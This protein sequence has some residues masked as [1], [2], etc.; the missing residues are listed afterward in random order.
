[1]RAFTIAIAFSLAIFTYLGNSPADPAPE[2]EN[3]T[4]GVS[5][6]N[7]GYISA[8]VMYKDTMLIVVTKAGVA[9]IVFDEPVDKGRNYRFR[10]LPAD[11]TKEVTGQGAVWETYLDGKYEGANATIKAGGISI[12]WSAGGNDRGWLYYEP[13]KTRMQIATAKRF[14]DRKSPVTNQ[15]VEKL[16]LKRFRKQP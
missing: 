2:E 4:Y 10:F 3:Q 8:P 1:M 5:N 15:K 16:D 14:Q 7:T 12:G 9:A 11:G 6:D 13:E